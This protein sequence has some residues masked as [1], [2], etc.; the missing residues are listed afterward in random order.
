MMYQ[1]PPLNALHV[2]E[3]VA[4]H[5]SF[6]EAA[7][8][9]DVTPTAVS[10]QIKVL[11][12][13]LGLPLIRRRP[14]PIALTEAGLKLYP[15]L[16]RS[17]GE[18]SIAIDQLTRTRDTKEL[19]VSVTPVFAAKWLVPRLSDFQRNYPEIDLR[20]HT[21]NDVVNLQKGTV[22]VAIRYGRGHYPGLSVNSL[23]SDT[24]I[25]V[26]SPLLLM[27]KKSL[28][29]PADLV[30]FPLLQF[31]WTHLGPD[32]PTWKNWL[33]TAGI[34][35]ID[36][37]RGIKF[38]EESL[39]IQAAIAGQGVALCSSIHVADDLALG[40]LV[41]PLDIVL[42]GFTYTAVYLEKHSKKLL[43]Q[44]FLEWLTSAATGL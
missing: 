17:L 11:E 3:V 34:H 15:V 44:T 37:N 42:P 4:R 29:Y 2:F 43:I 16:H 24:F 6:Q 36:L 9:L 35:S 30:H 23:M 22:D 13:A 14:R 1:L 20:L 25:P 12:S 21:S 18:I 33:E 19:T 7:I 40:I 5:L 27:R 31:E 32:A 8:E 38:D 10:H 28:K 41:T 26:C 39:A